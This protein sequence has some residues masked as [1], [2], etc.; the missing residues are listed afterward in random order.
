MLALAV[1]SEVADAVRLA[2]LSLEEVEVGPGDE[3]LE[4]AL[5]EAE[6]EA[7]GGPCQGT[8]HDGVTTAV[9]RLYRR[10]GIDPTKTRPSSEALARRVRRGAPFPRVNVL[11]DV[12]NWC[13]ME[14]GLPFGL[15][16]AARIDGAIECRIGRVDEAYPGIRKDV[17]HVA[18]RLVL[19]DQA[20]PFGNPTSDSSRTMITS[21][22]TCAL[23]VVFAP[24]A[25]A[26][27]VLVR[28]VETTADRMAAFARPRH[29]VQW[30]ADDGVQFG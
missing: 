27:A 3:R 21:K 9:R 25:L 22:T 13:S 5:A 4:A 8:D 10:F 12:C 28:T 20:G 16:D 2:G 18:G 15:Y 29:V 6:A 30:S 11:V 26:A 7:A 24:V 1:A 14:S 17:V 23:V 19:A